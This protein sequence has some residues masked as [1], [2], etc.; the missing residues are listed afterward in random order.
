MEVNAATYKSQEKGRDRWGRDVGAAG[1]HLPSLVHSVGAGFC[2]EEE[3]TGLR[4]TCTLNR[5]RF[6]I[7]GHDEVWGFPGKAVIVLKGVGGKSCAKHSLP[8]TL[9]PQAQLPSLGTDDWE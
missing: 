8:G 4:S 6:T 1:H 3:W 2:E 9:P 7:S 5:F